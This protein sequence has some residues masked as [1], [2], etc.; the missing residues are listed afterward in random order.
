MTYRT[1]DVTCS[2][3]SDSVKAGIAFSGSMLAGWAV[4][5]NPEVGTLAL[6]GYLGCSNVSSAEAVT[7]LKALPYEVL[8]NGTAALEKQVRLNLL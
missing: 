4:T 7:C 5:K 2:Q 8:L 3:I 1:Y 6:A